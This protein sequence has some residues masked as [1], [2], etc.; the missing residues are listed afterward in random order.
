[1]NPSIF[2]YA[3]EHTKRDQLWL[4]FVVLVSLPFYFMSLD[5]PKRI[6]D[7]P[8]RG[9][10]HTEAGTWTAMRLTVDWPAW[11]GGNGQSLVLLDGI[12]L[13]RVPMLVYLCVLFLFFV[14]VNGLIKYYI[15]TYKGRLGERMLRRIR[16]ELVDRLLRFPMA[17]FRRIRSS[18]VAT[19]VKDEVEPLGG[20]I[21]EAF[22]TPA[23][24]ISQAAVAMLFILLQSL[25]LG[26]VAGAVVAVQVIIIPRL[27]RR[28]LILGRQRQLTAR[29]LAGRVGELVESISSIRSNDTSNWERAEI[30]SR[31]GRIFFIRFDIYQW[32]FL[33]K[34]LNN[35]LAQVTP[36]IFYL[37]GGYLVIQGQLEIGQLVAVIAAYKDLPAPLK[38]LI[39][40]DQIR[41]DVQVKYTTVVEQFAQGKVLDQ[42]VQKVEPEAPPRIEREIAAV[43][44]AIRDDSGGSL[45][46]PT[47]LRLTPGEAVAAVGAVGAGAEYVAEAFARLAEPASGR[48][49]FDGTPIDTL[50]EAFTGRRTGYV[51]SG[52]YFP[53]SSLRDALLYGLRHVPVRPATKD[54]RAEARRRA[55][56]RKAGNID[57]D[58]DDDWIDYEAAGATGPEDLLD[59]M[60]EVLALVGLEDDVYRQ[61]LRSPLPADAPETVVAAVLEAR[62]DFRSRLEQAGAELYVETFD[63]QRYIVN[64]SVLENLIFGVLVPGAIEGQ[65]IE[66]HPYMVAILAETGLESR[67]IAMG[68]QIAEALID[69]FGD[70]APDNPLLERMDL[71]SPEE[72]DRY[73]AILRR[74]AAPD[75]VP[76]ADDGY[77]LLRLAFG[78]IE[79]RHRLGLLDE[80][81]REAV[82]AARRAFREKLPEELAGAVYFYEPDALN[83][84]ASLQDNVL[85]GRVVDVYADA[86]QRTS[87][88]LHETLDAL[89]LSPTIVALGLEMDIGSGAKRLSPA[90]RQKLALAR[91]LLKRP[92][93]LVVNRALSALDGE[94]QQA[95]IE[96][97][98]ERSRS[99]G[100]HRHA[101]FWVLSNPAHAA[102]FDKVAT[103]ENGRLVGHEHEN[104]AESLVAAQ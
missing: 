99:P 70:M 98:L 61:G 67:L 4:L 74:V 76:D 58:I 87:A 9:A 46:E 86:V 72:I 28:L 14:L 27:R 92:D 89:D 49:Q 36:F 59:R 97:V 41:L 13:D 104:A 102:P 34:F 62:K 32:K 82:L 20:F 42:F 52:T 54:E 80:P 75:A 43:N 31:L 94:T 60:R 53:Q 2:R 25:P 24:L 30:S 64:A 81:L 40:W 8:I 12:Q 90:Q 79:P 45:L 18:E 66:R 100:G 73:R 69:L 88:L 48:V 23:L 33:V 29:R 37:A 57:L 84:A 78:Y 1:M 47:T 26:L 5:L 44:L 3:W 15:S 95:I 55:E 68:R 21:G 103:F 96:R 22:V 35:L 83:P 56:A 10:G 77:A 17:A 63:P 39:D 71:L 6:I 16:Y 51:E 50:P 101:T 93:L 85:F 11:L 7:G 38:E 65:L 19:M 91:A